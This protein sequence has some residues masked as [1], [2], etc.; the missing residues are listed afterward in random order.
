[1]SSKTEE[2]AHA[3]LNR[4]V[5]IKKELNS[6]SKEKRPKYSTECNNLQDCERWR[7]QVI[8]EIS[9]KV[10]DIQNASLGEFRIREM[11]D[12]INKLFREKMHWEDRIKELGGPDYKKLAPKTYDAEGYEVPNSGGYKYWGAAK[13][14]P[15]VREL[16]AIH[17]P[18]PPRKNIIDMYKGIDKEYYGE[19]DEEEEELERLEKEEEDKIKKEYFNQ[20][21]DEDGIPSKKRKINNEDTQVVNQLSVKE[22]SSSEFEKF[23]KLHSG[24]IDDIVKNE[25]NLTISKPLT[26]EELEKDLI[27]KKK[28]QILRM[29]NN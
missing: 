28:A 19:D 26:K 4:W 20:L 27:E 25:K 17:V 21:E 15:G 11:N 14:L 16:F 13:D 3:M 8:K 10:A 9:K 1:M 23:K 18:N 6:R 7:A 22:I 12:E 5:A 29:L 24:Y 2:K